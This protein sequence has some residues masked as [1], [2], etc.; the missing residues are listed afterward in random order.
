MNEH[1]I[2]K[3]LAEYG[4]APVNITLISERK[5]RSVWKITGDKKSYALK[6]VQPQIAEIISNVGVYLFNRGVPVITVL[7]TLKN[8][9]FVK[10]K[11]ISF[12]LFPWFEGE[13]IVYDTPGAMEKMS[14]LLANFHEAS[15]GYEGTGHPIKKKQ[16]DYVRETRKMNDV[17]EKLI[18]KDSPMVKVFSSHYDWLQKRCIWVM[19]RLPDILAAP[20]KFN[21]DSLLSHGDYARVNILSDKNGDWKIIDLDTVAISHP[22]TDVSKMITLINHDLGN[23]DSKRYQFI[24]ECYRKIRPFSEDEEELL[25][26]DQCFPRQAIDLLKCYFNKSG[27]TTLV[28]ELE[29]CLATEREKLKDF[30]IHL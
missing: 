24:L 4:I 15:R 29:R 23:W 19:E 2:L 13:A 5:N 18:H 10:R 21:P 30:Q 16:M 14:T 12:V 1:I 28:E 26:I 9:F 11:N 6:S 17:Y 25:M 3:V 20:A 22:M 27:S 7:P 8:D